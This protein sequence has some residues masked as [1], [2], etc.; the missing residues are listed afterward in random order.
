MKRLFYPVFLL[1]L[2]ILNFNCQKEI[3]TGWA[4]IPNGTTIN[5]TIQG[6]ILDENGQPA[7]GVQVKAGSITAITDSKGFFRIVKTNVDKNAALVTAEKTGYFKAYRTFIA[8]N[9]SNHVTIKLIKKTLAGTIASAS[10]GDVVLTNGTKIS[11]PVNS[12]IKAS[13]GSYSGT[14]NVYAAYIDPTAADITQTIPGSFM[15]DDKNNKRGLLT[16]YGMLAV[17]LESASGEK[18]QIANGNKATLTAPI[19]ASLSG[20]APASI[21]LWYIDEQTGIW[22]EQ[23]VATKNGNMY[24]GEVSHFSFWNYDI[25]VPSVLLSMTLKTPDGN[26]L[27]NVC[28]NLTRNNGMQA[29]GYT[30]AQGFVS[31][32]VPANETMLMEVRD[33]CWTTVYSQNIGPFAQATNL[34]VVTVP[35]T[36]T[37]VIAIEGTVLNCSGAPVSNGYAIIYYDY[38]PR[39]VNTNSAGHFSFAFIRCTSSA[40]TCD[41]TGVDNITQQQGSVNGITIISPLTH[42]GNITACGLSSSEYINYD[43]DGTNYA[44]VISSPND[45]LYAGTGNQGTNYVTNFWAVKWPKNV[46]L[47][48]NSN[49]E[50]PGTYPL[51]Q[52]GANFYYAG[53]LLPPSN[54]TLSTFPAVSGFYEGNF[55]ASFKDSVNLSVTHTLS[56]NFRLRRQY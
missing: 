49:A 7:T 53:S 41:I 15:A 1:F 36:A 4:P 11:L 2:S 17:E 31:G 46:N 43:F 3:G 19:P 24:V 18:L 30:D 9:S 8:S 21:P 50:A 5:A 27:V 33:E 35:N 6:R 34:G 40:V 26:P 47:S 55:T 16:S 10:G 39:Y 14:I 38:Y 29:P 51:I 25:Y 37:S 44:I 12:V 48:F 28:V 52:A 42:A 45:T 23:G 32:L 54:I 20:S 56:G 13:G 22:K